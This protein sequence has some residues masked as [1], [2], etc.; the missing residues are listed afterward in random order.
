[1]K[2][3]L[4]LDRDGTLIIEPSDTFQVD[5][6]EK[7][8]YLPGVFRNLYRISQNLDY[9]LVIVSNQDGLGTPAYPKEA[10]DLIQEKMIRAF[11][12]EGITFNAIHIDPS[13]PEEGSPNRKPGTGMLTKYFSRDY[14]LSE[15]YV[16]GD[17]VT[18][19][20]LARNIGARGILIGNE[21]LRKEIEDKNLEEACILVADNWD[22]ISDYFFNRSRSVK[23][24]RKTK[25]TQIKVELNID[26]TGKN[27]I[28]TGLGFFDHMLE[29]IAKHGNC[30][31]YIEV[32]GDLNVDE[33][34]TIEDTAIVL[35]EAFFQALGN[36]R[37]IE[38][39]GYMLPM[40]DSHALV[41]LD[42]GG[43]SWLEWK[44]KFNRERVGDMPAE[45]FCH[46]FKS[47]TDAAKCNLLIMA[48]GNN[49]HHKIEAIFKTFAKA[50]KMAV[51]REKFNFNL[52][53]T[54]GLL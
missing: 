44:A 13:L 7:L 21:K 34:H 2:K 35:G 39:Y 45:M 46:F 11:Q 1:M 12:N 53:S 41:T 32:E 22:N 36:K 3:I 9:E 29:Q 6:L 30:D 23:I 24:E 17:R 48:D 37:G 18:D 10:F 25:E 38:R 40:D 8:E 52:P 49:E 43:R 50:I 26:G 47:F 51:K 16:I 20:E 27:Q 42:F 33:H 31:L 5:S 19:I 14:N 4:F 15:S 54:K 28:N